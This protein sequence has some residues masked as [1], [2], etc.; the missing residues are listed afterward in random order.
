VISIRDIIRGWNRFFF[1][2]ISPLPMAVYR[3]L[4]GLL[5]LANQLL[6]LPDV[7]TWFSDRGA[8]SFAT[9]RRVSGGSG[10]NVFNFLPHG[11]AMVW[12][13]FVLSCFAAISLAAGFFTRT[14]AFLTFL[15]FVTLDHRNPMILNSGDTFLRLG[16]FF[17]MFSHAG[18]ALSVDEWRRRKRGEKSATAYP[19]WAMRV[20]QVQLSFVYFYA[21]IWKISG[22]M[23]MSGTAVY[24]TSRLFEFWRFPVPYVFEHF[25]TIKL[26][27]WGTLLI[28]FALGT[29]V[30]IKELRYAVLLAGILLHI[31]IDYSMNIPLFGFIMASAY[32]TFVDP[33]DLERWL[34]PVIRKARLEGL[35]PARS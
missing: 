27:T 14:S 1:E 8:L 10:L 26:W 20:L 6:L 28:E 19:P 35:G 32:V 3:I 34:A 29:L 9:A 25:W 21:F 31:G 24:Y 16:T 22:T 23:W 15:F 7:M 11:D 2:P 17:V 4:L 13:V 12:I 18:R 33:A 30:W 5:V